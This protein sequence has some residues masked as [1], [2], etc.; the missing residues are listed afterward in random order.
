MTERKDVYETW[1]SLSQ[2]I[3]SCEHTN[4]IS[5]TD[6]RATLRVCP[7]CGSRCILPAAVDHWIKPTFI[8]MMAQKRKN[9]KNTAAEL[10]DL[11]KKNG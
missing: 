6:G 5:F 1:E 10:E 3:E 4:P 11:T 2:A 9:P 7:A 8:G